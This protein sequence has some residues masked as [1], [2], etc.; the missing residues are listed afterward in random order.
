[1]EAEIQRRW[2]AE[3]AHIRFNARSQFDVSLALLTTI[4]LPPIYTLQ[5]PHSH[6]R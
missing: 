5:R 6:T 2:E 3:Q 4:I 1:M